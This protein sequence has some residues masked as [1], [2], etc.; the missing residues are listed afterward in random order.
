MYLGSLFQCMFGDVRNTYLGVRP[1]LA[2]GSVGFALTPDDRSRGRWFAPFVNG[3]WTGH[4]IQAPLVGDATGIVS[5]QAGAAAVS[6]WFEEVGPWQTFG[7]VVPDLQA[8]ANDQQNA[9]RREFDW[10][11][12]YSVTPVD[13]DAQL[14]SIVVTGAARGVNVAP[15][16]EFPT[17]GRLNYTI[18]TAGG[19][20]MI[21]F[22]SGTTLVAQG[23]R[24]GNGAVTCAAVAGSGLSVACV[25]TYTADV[26]PSVAILDCRWPAA[27]QIH[28]TT[29]AL[30]Y[31]RNPEVLY[32]DNG[33]SAYGYT[34]PALLPGTYN[35]NVLTVDDD[36]NVQTTI[37]GQTAFMISAVP[38]SP[39]ITSVSGGV[40]HWTPGESGDTFKLYSSAVNGPINFGQNAA[41]A[42]VG[43]TAVNATSANAPAV[44]IPVVNRETPYTALASA[45]DAA[46]AALN[47]S[48]A[49]AGTEISP[50]PAAWTVHANTALG[51]ATLVID[52]NADTGLI[53]VNDTFKVGADATVY[54][55]IAYN[56][57]THTI[58]FVPTL[59]ANAMAG[60]HVVVTSARNPAWHNSFAADLATQ[61][62]AID[63]AIQTFSASITIDLRQILDLNDAAAA[64]LVARARQLAVPN[65]WTLNAD[66]AIGN[67][68]ATL[69]GGAGSFGYQSF[70]TFLQDTERYQ[71]ISWNGAAIAFTPGST[72]A[73]T[74]GTKVCPVGPV[75]AADWQAQIRVAYGAYLAFLG[76]VLNG[77]ATRYKFPDGT[78]DTQSE[79][80][81]PIHL[82]DVVTP[83]VPPMIVRY[84]VRATKGGIEETDDQIFAVEFDAGGTSLNPRPNTPYVVLPVSLRGT[85]IPIT[86]GVIED[87]ATVPAAYVHMYVQPDDGSAFDFTAPD[88]TAALPAPTFNSHQA[89]LTVPEP[90]GA[91]FFG[92]R[93]GSTLAAGWYRV[94]VRSA[95]AD[96]TLSAGR[97]EDRIYVTDSVPGGVLNLTSVGVR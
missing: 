94:A 40:V 78:T 10:V 1:W 27:Y 85:A 71:V 65:G 36:G 82:L 4:N 74:A 31:P 88:A 90:L 52:P 11:A 95:A 30:V 93:F 87:N 8:K 43:P 72:T 37:V 19:A 68:M 33:S 47:T 6:L 24:T 61:A 53:L 41:P 75:N 66:I 70:F 76:S 46:A 17:R 29:A 59:V 20:H 89:T 22:Y 13:G 9:T 26:L 12:P 3:K 96:G 60:A 58:S 45:I 48:Y 84:A 79:A 28:F 14:S 80:I 35:W 23:S 62:A 73:W 63:T 92:D 83:F 34:T 81:P 77:D 25:L 16:T 51:S 49:S 39:T 5:A 15:V 56:A 55:T 57:G 42:I 97:V 64:V 18:S 91:R 69:T 67:T 38:K 54:T 32:I 2:G 86:A 7:D 21:S 50:V 44:T